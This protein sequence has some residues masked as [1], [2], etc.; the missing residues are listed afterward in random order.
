V[1]A[2]L[3]ETGQIQINK[4]NLSFCVSGSLQLL[5]MIHC[6]CGVVAHLPVT[7]WYCSTFVKK[8]LRKPLPMS[9]FQV[10]LAVILAAYASSACSSSA[11]G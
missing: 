10:T 7:V 3:P 5:L 2:H 11:C 1:G 6:W 9:L 4:I 8:S